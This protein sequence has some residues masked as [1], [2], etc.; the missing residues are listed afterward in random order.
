MVPRLSCQHL[1]IS[2]L[3]QHVWKSWQGCLH[4]LSLWLFTFELSF[5]EER[6]TSH[7]PFQNNLLT[8]KSIYVSILLNTWNGNFWNSPCFKKK[9]KC[10]WQNTFGNLANLRCLLWDVWWTQTQLCTLVPTD[11]AFFPQSSK[12]LCM[13]AAY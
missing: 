5:M 2:T 9:G 3:F 1:E 4:P 10:M 8:A 11:M 13:L 12:H 6:K 7:T